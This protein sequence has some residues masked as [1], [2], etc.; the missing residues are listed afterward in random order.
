LILFFVVRH[1]DRE[2]TK[3]LAK[4]KSQAETDMLTGQPNRYGL[5]SYAEKRV[6]DNPYTALFIDLSKFKHLNDT[7][8]HRVGDEALIAIARRINQTLKDGD[9]LV[10]FGGD[11]FLIMTSETQSGILEKKA[12]RV[13]KA[14]E[15]PLRLG[16]K[17]VEIWANIGIASYPDDGEDVMEVISS[18]D[19]AM[20]E[21]K[22]KVI[23]WCFFDQKIKQ[24][25]LGA[26]QIENDII[27]AL[28]YDEFSL[29]YQPQINNIGELIGVEAL[30]R[31]NHREKG[32][33]PPDEYINIAEHRGLMPQLGEHVL[34]L[35]A[36]DMNGLLS[37]ISHPITLS[38]NVSVSQ[39]SSPNFAS[40]LI[41]ILGGIKGVQTNIVLEV[42]ESLFI[43]DTS[44]VNRA[45]HEIKQHGMM[46]SLDDFG[47]GYSSL[48]LLRVLD[49]D[50]L[51]IDRS[52]ITPITQNNDALSVVKSIVDIGHTLGMSVLSEGIETKEQLALLT[53]IGC[54]RF[55]GF[56]F[57]K[58]LSPAALLEFINNP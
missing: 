5:L 52:L 9:M 58:P 48:S 10:R 29:A 55:Q 56:Y 12:L 20:Y 7:L 1:V 51:K 21:A 8:G 38:I 50:E 49:I 45:L 28:K 6:T 26:I 40:N 33:I 57:S 23:P 42:T 25:H 46:I 37:K 53:E 22:Q 27:E 13:I 39:F 24:K 14:I 34:R 43:G 17:I 54:D 4:I 2:N 16:N 15:A 30:L 47:T 11:E 31:W 36:K 41:E 32:A 3:T 19:L 44:E 18:A 35:A